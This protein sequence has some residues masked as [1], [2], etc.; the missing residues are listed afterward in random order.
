MTRRRAYEVAPRRREEPTHVH[1]H[2]CRLTTFENG[3]VVVYRGVR[4]VTDWL[5]R[6]GDL[7]SE[8]HG[9]AR[10]GTETS[11]AVSVPVRAPALLSAA[12]THP[13]KE[14]PPASGRPTPRDD[15]AGLS[16]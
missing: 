16:S 3:E 9:Y 14:R 4:A 13:R 12:P 1:T 8:R 10:S 11:G 2:T 7:A 5:K 6:V 15:P